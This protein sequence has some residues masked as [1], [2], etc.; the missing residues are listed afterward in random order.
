[1]TL[2]D[3]QSRRA[4]RGIDAYST[5]EVGHAQTRSGIVLQLRSKRVR[6]VLESAFDLAG[7]QRT[8]L[9]C[10]SGWWAA[11]VCHA[12]LAGGI[13][14]AVQRVPAPGRPHAVL[15]VERGDILGAGD[16]PMARLEP[17]GPWLDLRGETALACGPGPSDLE[18]FA[19]S[20]GLDVPRAELLRMFDLGVIEWEA[21]TVS[22]R[23]RRLVSVA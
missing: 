11:L 2:V 5:I 23:R 4:H 18:A 15:V 19:R 20:R 12:A 17:F 13:T 22:G 3:A 9:P 21:G 8:R 14:A 7:L 6:D 16:W 1:M 10:D